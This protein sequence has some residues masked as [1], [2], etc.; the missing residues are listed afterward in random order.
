MKRIFLIILGSVLSFFTIKAQELEWV[1]QIGGEG[2]ST[3]TRV[4]ALDSVGNTYVAGSFNDTIDVDPY[5]NRSLNF[6][7]R[8]GRNG[9]IVK[10][11][12]AGQL[13]WAKQLKVKQNNNISALIFFRDLTVDKMGNILLTGSFKGTV[14]FNPGSGTANLKTNGYDQD[15]FIQKL[16]A[17]GNFIWAKRIGGSV[18]DQGHSVTTD[19]TGAVYLTGEFQYNVDFDPGAG[20]NNLSSNGLSDIFVCKLD[21]NGNFSWVKQ[22][23]SAGQDRGVSIVLDNSGNVNVMVQFTDVADFNPGAGTFQLS[24]SGGRSAIVKLDPS[25][26][27]IWAK[28]IG[29]NPKAMTIDP[30]G[31]FYVTG[32]FYDTTS[33]DLGNGT[34]NLV[35]KGESDIFI[36]KLN[37]SGNLLWVK[38][39]GSKDVDYANSVV[40]TPDGHVF[41]GGIFRDSVDFNPGTGMAQRYSLNKERSLFI[42]K[43]D[44]SGTFTWV[45]QITNGF[46]NKPNSN[47]WPADSLAKF[48]IDR[49][50]N[51]YSAGSFIDSTDFAPGKNQVTLQSFGRIDAFIHKMSLNNISIKED[52]LKHSF[53]VYPN[54]TH[55]STTLDLGATFSKIELTVSDITGRKIMHKTL[56]GHQ[57]VEIELPGKAGIYF[58]HINADQQSEVLK[59][60]KK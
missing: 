27:F 50:G 38:S 34:F 6:I 55:E 52:A 41:I 20:S 10:I 28:K 9:F 14:D 36:S 35:P 47:F 4:M 57:Q 22:I 33:F 16:D 3:V 45:R 40:L 51:V 49:L 32:S 19:A 17:S 26:N 2:G 25:G 23:G 31:Q 1:K 21:A 39:M 7:A 18:H 56:K 29:G 53:T 30:S 11:D 13:I 5:A 24:P 54:P 8:N 15:I 60:M 42:L 37:S 58:I 43:L 44:T 48:A 46:K 12:S 59:V